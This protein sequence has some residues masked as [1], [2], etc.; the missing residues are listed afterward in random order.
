[1]NNPLGFN[2]NNHLHIVAYLDEL[3]ND[4]LS[5]KIAISANDESI[6]EKDWQKAENLIFDFP[7]NLKPRTKYEVNVSIKDND[8]TINQKS[9]FE[10]G[11]MGESLLGNWIGTEH[12]DLHSIVLQKEF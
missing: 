7:I 9:H 1:M 10:T 4:S 8:Q 6:Y 2:L 11:M 5:K 12:K 3:T